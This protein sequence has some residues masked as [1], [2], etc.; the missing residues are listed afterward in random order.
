MAQNFTRSKEVQLTGI[1][2]KNISGS[3]TRPADTTTYAA[4]DLVA[5]STTA[6][7]VVPITLSAAR[8]SGGSFSLRRA[9]I[10]KSSTGIVGAAFRVHFFLAVPSTITNGDN[11][12]FSVSGSDDYIGAMDVIVDRVF[13]DGSVG[14]G[15]P[16]SGIE[17]S[18]ELASGTNIYALIEARAAYVPASGET[19][20]LSVEVFQN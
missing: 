5:N 19:I 3:F 12:A 8:V 10:R 6:G 7:S 4:E 11:G 16:I 1:K 20:A 18:Q 17:I 15:E 9:K 2:I 13:T 14:L